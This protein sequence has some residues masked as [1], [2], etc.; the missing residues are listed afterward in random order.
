MV[1]PKGVRLR[2]EQMLAGFQS[3]LP[4]PS[5]ETLAREAWTGGRN[6]TFCCADAHEL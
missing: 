1:G 6:L 4:E 5:G 3:E 2:L